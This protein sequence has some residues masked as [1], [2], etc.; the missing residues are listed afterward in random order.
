MPL[1]ETINKYLTKLDYKVDEIIE[2]YGAEEI[3]SYFLN[4]ENLI[5]SDSLLLIRDFYLGAD[6]NS[7]LKNQFHSA[8]LENDYQTFLKNNLRSDNMAIINETI[9]CAGK[10]TLAENI[11]LLKEVESKFLEYKAFPVLGKLYFEV[12]WIERSNQLKE[13]YTQPNKNDIISCLVY[14]NF[15]SSV[16]YKQTAFEA[17]EKHC[18][19]SKYLTQKELKSFDQILIRM[20]NDLYFQEKIYLKDFYPVACDYFKYLQ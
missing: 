4:S 8:L 1:K 11:A 19:E 5:C 12:S 3:V 9:Y 20:N 10:L 6:Y 16:G 2:K 14:L 15:W 18:L 13:S 17:L 7:G